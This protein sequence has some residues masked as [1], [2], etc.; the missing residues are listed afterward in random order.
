MR[1]GSGREALD[2]AK[3]AEPAQLHGRINVWGWNIAAKSLKSLLPA[4]AEL[5]HRPIPFHALRRAWL[6]AVSAWYRFQDK[7]S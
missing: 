6:P 3:L 2:P 7:R 1:S 5:A 4:F